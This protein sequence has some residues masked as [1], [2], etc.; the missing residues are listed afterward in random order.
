MA[1][2]VVNDREESL[3]L[4]EIGQGEEDSFSGS[5]ALIDFLKFQTNDRRFD[6]IP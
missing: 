1:K 6:R 2:F 4:Q 3:W 5:S